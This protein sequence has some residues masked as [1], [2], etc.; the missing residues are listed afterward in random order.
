MQTR[1]VTSDDIERQ[2]ILEWAVLHAKGRRRYI[3]LWGVLPWVAVFSILRA[4]VEHFLNSPSWWIH[5][6]FM[7]PFAAAAGVFMGNVSWKEN[8]KKYADLLQ[9]YGDTQLDHGR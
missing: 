6:A 8:E 1:T 4:V 2:F 9:K 7:G 5:I 3:V